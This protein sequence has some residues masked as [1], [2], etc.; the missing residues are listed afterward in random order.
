MSL[1]FMGGQGYAYSS[2]KGKYVVKVEDEEFEFDYLAE[3][4]EFYNNLNVNKAIWDCSNDIPE[5][6]ESHEI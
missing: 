3:A 6:L 1:R 2:D 4:R 5:L